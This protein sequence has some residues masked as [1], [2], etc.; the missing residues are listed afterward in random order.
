MQKVKFRTLYIAPTLILIGLM[1]L[2]FTSLISATYR[3]VEFVSA[4][5]TAEN[6]PGNQFSTIPGIS[7]DGRYVVFYSNA[8]NIVEN[9]LNSGSDIFVRDLL[10]HTS[11]R[12]SV[13]SDGTEADCESLF[14]SCNI[15]PSIS[16]NGRYV[17]FFS[18]ATNLFPGDTDNTVDLFIHDMQ[19]GETKRI[20]GA[21]PEG[22]QKCDDTLAA[23]SPPAF[24]T[25]DG[26]YLVFLS[27]ASDLVSGDTNGSPDIFVLD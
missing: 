15:F 10:T 16:G 13:A 24:I 11:T 6:Q 4:A 12:A 26:H 8:S 20:K 9:D 18:L 5:Y 3:S 21:L 22:M 27:T 1:L 19:T 17:T 2:F 25:Y 14:D 7:K 23:C